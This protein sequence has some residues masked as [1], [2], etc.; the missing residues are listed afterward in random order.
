MTTAQTTVSQITGLLT[1]EAAAEVLSCTPIAVMRLIARGALAATRL[2]DDGDWRVRASDVDAYIG[3]GA[4]GFDAPK[5][6]FMDGDASR[7]SWFDTPA[8]PANQL[9]DAIAAMAAPQR[10]SD[11]DY[12]RQAASAT[13][14]I[15]VDVQLQRRNAAAPGFYRRLRCATAA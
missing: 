3:R 6:E 4:P 5:F 13:S 2:G 11:S 8:W 15:L 7:P 1:L 9:A 10:L 14:S 12:E